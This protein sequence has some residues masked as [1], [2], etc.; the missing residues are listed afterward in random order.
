LGFHANKRDEYNKANIRKKSCHH[1][2]YCQ[3]R[4]FHKLDLFAKMH[5]KCDMYISLLNYFIDVT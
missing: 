5:R 3:G 1:L 4:V 2:L